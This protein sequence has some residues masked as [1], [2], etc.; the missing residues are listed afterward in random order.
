MWIMESH[1]VFKKL[2]KLF[3]CLF[4][5]AFI[6]SK[7]S[8]QVAGPLDTIYTAN[9]SLQSCVVNIPVNNINVP[10]VVSGYN[11]G[12]YTMMM[13]MTNLC[14]LPGNPAGCVDVAGNLSATSTIWNTIGGQT[15]SG[16]PNPIQSLLC[17]QGA[18]GRCN[19]F[20]QMN[21]I[22]N[23]L[24][25]GNGNIA[26]Q[27]RASVVRNTTWNM[28]GFGG[29]ATGVRTPSFNAPVTM[30]LNLPSYFEWMSGRDVGTGNSLSITA[31]CASNTLGARF[32]QAR[33]GNTNCLA[34][35]INTAPASHPPVATGYS[36]PMLRSAGDTV[37]RIAG[38]T[39]NSIT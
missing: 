23:V 24:G 35:N 21:N 26:G 9:P 10:W 30:P 2:L 1:L 31:N 19:Y 28:D 14:T 15:A 13:S 5:L 39:T 32:T 38:F 33:F 4:F 11:D 36:Q 3:A 6:P 17:S 25:D 34:Q 12:G 27:P 37:W 22:W 16:D 7:V 18:S 29:G 20:A 8:A